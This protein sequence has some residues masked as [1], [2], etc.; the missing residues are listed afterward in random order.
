MFARVSM[1]QASPEHLEEGI[2][3]VQSTPSPGDQGL[4]GFKGAFLLVDRKSAKV[5][6]ITLWEAEQDVQASAVGASRLRAAIGQAF[7]FTGTPA[8]EVYE[9]ASV[10]EVSGGDR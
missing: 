2:R 8:V 7:G 5:I 3:Y 9:V 4:A 6:T 1:L 10:L